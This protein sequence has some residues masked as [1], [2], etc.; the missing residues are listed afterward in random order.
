MV[1]AYGGRNKRMLWR[2]YGC[3]KQF[4]V[5]IGTVMEDS[6][7]PAR[8]WVH[9]FWRA[10]ASKKGVS[11]LQIKRE[12]GLSYK[13][14]LFLMHRIR[15]AMTDS[16]IPGGKLSGTVE[17]D[18]TYVGGKVRGGKRG[19]PGIDSN[20][21]PVFAMVER[22]GRVRAMPMR[23]SA[24][25]LKTALLEHVDVSKANLMTDENQGYISAGRDFALGHTTVNHSQKE[26]V[27]GMAYT[28]T[29]EGFFALLKRGIMGTFHS[30]SKQHLHR[31]VT[32]FE[33]RYNL[34]NVDDG[35][36]TLRAIKGGEWKRLRYRTK[37]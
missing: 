5:R 30:V 1:G 14:A 23:V 2:C 18:E 3:R 15:W 32:E 31:Y 34:R 17:A 8:Y 6:R 12:T 9:A 37:G 28:N 36:R 22:E 27:R 16:T 20:K 13:S 7:I 21:T 25:D 33:F 26:Y 24:N 35:E 29:V 4:S 19:R 11:A 10:C